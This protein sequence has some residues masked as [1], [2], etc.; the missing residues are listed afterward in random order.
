MKF[1]YVCYILVSAVT[2]LACTNTYNKRALFYFSSSFYAC[3]E[4][5]RLDIMILK[6]LV[7]LLSANYVHMVYLERSGVMNIQTTP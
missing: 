5:P 6:V 1:M 4:L 2:A 3:E 7:I